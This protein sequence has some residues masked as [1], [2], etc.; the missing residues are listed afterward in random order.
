MTSMSNKMQYSLILIVFFYNKASFPR[1]IS[2]EKM[3]T[4]FGLISI[5]LLGLSP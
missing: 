3:N 1:V 5:A 2:S 4:S